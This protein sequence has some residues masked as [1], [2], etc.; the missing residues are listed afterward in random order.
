M[1]GR[2]RALCAVSAVFICDFNKRAGGAVQVFGNTYE[3]F[4]IPNFHLQ[5]IVEDYG[6]D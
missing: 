3:D 4:Q 2:L 5:C 1:I 6:N